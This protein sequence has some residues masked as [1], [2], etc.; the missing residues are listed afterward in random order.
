MNIQKGV[1]HKCSQLKG[2]TQ[3][4][5]FLVV[6]PLR[7]VGFKQ[8]KNKLGIH[9]VDLKNILKLWMVGTHSIWARMAPIKLALY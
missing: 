9:S 2:K 6:E 8:T 7:G 4:Q 3:K 1:M 5:S